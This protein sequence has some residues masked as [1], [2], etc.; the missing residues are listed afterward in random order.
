MPQQSAYFIVWIDMHVRPANRT[1]NLSTKV[2]KDSPMTDRF[3]KIVYLP[4]QSQASVKH[5]P[6]LDQNG[7]DQIVTQKGYSEKTRSSDGRFLRINYLPVTYWLKII[8]SLLCIVEHRPRSWIGPCIK[9]R[10]PSK[11]C[12][13]SNPKYSKSSFNKVSH[14]S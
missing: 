10:L 7:H 4:A 11:D 13:R 12:F 6:S 3:W 5:S 14:R 9:C 2:L 1:L 8:H